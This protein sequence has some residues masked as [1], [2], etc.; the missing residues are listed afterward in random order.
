M[1]IDQINRINEIVSQFRQK[2]DLQQGYIEIQL[3]NGISEK[4]WG[5]VVYRY[6]SSG[7]PT[8]NHLMNMPIKTI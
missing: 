6:Q 5:T 2:S 3:M 4:S 8:I 7:S 1:N